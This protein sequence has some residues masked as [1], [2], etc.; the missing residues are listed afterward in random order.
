MDGAT[1][2][3]TASDG[4]ASSEVT[5][6]GL[7]YCI[8]D[9]T[10]NIT[11][12]VEDPV[13]E[14]EQPAVA[15]AIMERHSAVEQVGFVREFTE[16]SPVQSAL[17]M[18]GGEFCGNATMSAAAL[19]LLRAEEAQGGASEETEYVRVL[20]SG[21]AEPVEVQLA[22]TGEAAFDAR[23]R[24]PR[25]RAIEQE[26][27]AFGQ[28]GGSLPVVR[29]EGISHAVIDED[30]PFFELLA[31]RQAAEQAVCAWCNELG[32]NGLGLMFV[33]GSGSTRTL[34]PLV[35]VPGGDTVFWENSCASGSSA[36][37]MYAAAQEGA[38]VQL[39]LCEPGGTLRVSSDPTVGETWLAGKVQL[40]EERP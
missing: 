20:V 26:E 37:G 33:Q 34:T 29:M 27:L 38:P 13:A 28:L 22:A 25:A 6:D 14:G 36:V 24:M 12:L 21:A 5:L 16:S 3:D 9:P 19:H 11:A 30:S 31:D 7:R 4:A 15:A 32:A 8:L 18:A 2:C 39:A 10:G 35:Y 1:A 23:V 40:V 17:R